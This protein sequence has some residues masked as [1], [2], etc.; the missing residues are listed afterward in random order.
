M[1][2][3]QPT[4]EQMSEARRRA[5]KTIFPYILMILAPTLGLALGLAIVL[6]LP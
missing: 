3:W 4:E 5:R 6:L 2:D 1:H